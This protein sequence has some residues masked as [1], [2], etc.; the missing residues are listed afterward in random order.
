MIFNSSSSSLYLNRR[1]A[2][3]TLALL[4][5]LLA[6]QYLLVDASRAN[7]LE[8]QQS[9]NGEPA[10]T[11]TDSHATG[12]ISG[13]VVSEDGQPLAYVRVVLISRKGGEG[14]R[15]A[16]AT[17]TD[18]RFR[19]RNVEA[20]AYS[21]ET[22]LPS[23]YSESDLAYDSGGRDYYR[24][25]DTATIR[26]FKGG[27]ITGKVTTTGGEPVIGARVSAVRVRDG[28]GRPV[29]DT[30]QY[31]GSFS[32]TD[33]RGVY[34]IYGLK[35]GSYLVAVGGDSPYGG[36][37]LSLY[38]G[39]APTYYPS[40][41]P[42]GASEVKVAAGQEATGIDIRFRG[43]QGHTVSGKVIGTLSQDSYT[44][45]RL[46]TVKGR[47]PVADTYL[48]GSGEN[49]SGGFEFDGVAD[50][51]YELTAESSSQKGAGFDSEPRRISVRGADVTGL[52]IVLAPRGS[53]SGH[54][55]M[56]A[57]HDAKDKC[58]N[59]R[60]ARPE[61]VVV[62][63]QLDRQG[64]SKVPQHSSFSSRLLEITPDNK[65][66]FTL[67]NVSA[68][69]YRIS[70]RLP[71]K[72]WYV[73]SIS[74]AGGA[75][76]TVASRASATPAANQTVVRDGLNIR[77]GENV[78][79]LAITV[80]EGAAYL[81]GKVVAQEGTALPVRLRIYLVPV[82]KESADDALRFPE[83]LIGPDGRFAFDNIAPGSYRIIAQPVS[84]SD[85]SA[86]SKQPVSWDADGRSKL[87][88]EAERINA[89]VDLKTCQSMDDYVLKYPQQAI[90]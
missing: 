62:K 15:S 77:S 7:R 19:F 29:V 31:G 73:R 36:Q 9:E 57:A 11:R 50:G 69:H 13:R 68:G 43:E 51:E 27:V 54:L 8:R 26:M 87:Y 34:R 61:E 55:I 64:A 44:E 84:D 65:G 4:L 70:L 6:F 72:S 37:P 28:D 59:E 85:D 41:T 18:G 42:D 17:G 2:G 46:T 40:A 71:G 22:Y 33:D 24:I 47:I 82:A 74:L 80:A 90:K 86:T 45:L 5:C 14:E 16:A 83:T 88:R 25:G 30:L 38:T 3:R 49:S 21:I 66:E 52:K 53:L 75:K 81:S 58:G 89:E 63:A 20:G 56:D 32:T 78:S 48:Y 1:N 79:G 60:G 23:Y 39:M 67:R 10:A 35:P 12:S 76:S